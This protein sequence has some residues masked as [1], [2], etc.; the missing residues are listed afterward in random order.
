VG[1]EDN[2]S[3]GNLVS[4]LTVQEAND[5][6]QFNEPN[7]LAGLRQDLDR[8]TVDRIKPKGGGATTNHELAK[9]SILFT[10]G[11]Y[12]FDAE[13][14]SRLIHVRRPEPKRLF[15][16]GLDVFASCGN[17]LAKSILLNEY[18]EAKK[19]PAYSDSLN[20]VKEEFSNYKHWNKTIYAKTFETILSLHTN[21]SAVPLFM[22]T[23]AWGKKDLNTS[24][25]AW[26][27]LKHD[28]L[29]YAEQPFAAQAGEGG[30]PPPPQHVSY[31]EPNVEFW[32]N[33]LQLLDF[34]EQKLTAMD[35]LTEHSKGIIGEL[36]EIA[37][38]L[39]TV[40]KKEL[41]KERVSNEEFN[42][43]SYL[44]G[45][46]E[47]LT[48]RIFDSDHLPEKE[49]LVALVADVYKYNNQYLEE[50]VGLVDEIYV[51]AEI[52]GKPYLTK[53]AVFSYYEFTNDGPL[54]D[55]EWRKQVTSG[56]A[57][58][59]P[60]WMDEIVVNTQSLQSKP[61]YSF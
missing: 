55:E 10:A 22:K 49:R 18:S 32:E 3:V 27:E 50:A 53:G 19:W 47:Y 43:L 29:L 6:S 54:T 41:T 51:V 11:R 7:K 34:E 38:L 23:P 8:V 30:G 5:P 16:K 45:K 31:V 60:V 13:I 20:F 9:K 59:R 42:D 26:T 25:A 37:S 15:P 56:G 21:S 17:E 35:L 12:T 39:L 36:K 14:L 4:L 24:L 1:E 58:D 48:F 61:T 44:G 40:S 46:I 28:M 2:M 57:P 33:A 52:N